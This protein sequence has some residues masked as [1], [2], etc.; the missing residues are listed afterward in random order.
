MRA[1]G[2]SRAAV[3]WIILFESI[4]LS[5]LGGLAGVL[6]GHVVLGLA[7]PIVEA[8]AGIVLKFWQFRWGRGLAVLGFSCLRLV[9]RGICRL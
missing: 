5:V 9:G 8:H 3:M 4:L 6:L 2:A 1:L 7:G